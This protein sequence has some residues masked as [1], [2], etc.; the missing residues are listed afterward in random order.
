MYKLINPICSPDGP[1]KKEE[2]EMT[3]SPLV[4]LNARLM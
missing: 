3:L 2:K 4:V 1:R